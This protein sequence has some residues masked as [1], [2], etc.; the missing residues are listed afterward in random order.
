MWDITT[1]EDKRIIENNA[2]GVASDFYT[3]GPLSTMENRAWDFLEWYLETMQ[4]DEGV[5]IAVK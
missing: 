4:R 2:K 3:P 1:Q 5:G